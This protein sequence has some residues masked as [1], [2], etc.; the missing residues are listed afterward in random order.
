M[1][2]MLVIGYG[3]ELRSDDGVGPKVA[4]A[5]AAM[6]WPGVDAI[7]CQQLTPELAELIAS[8]RAVIFVDAARDSGSEVQTQ[9]IEPSPTA[10]VMAHAGG[11]ESLLA[12][13]REWFGKCPPAWL[14]RVPA[15]TFDFGE[16]L[17]ALAEKGLAEAIEEIKGLCARHDSGGTIVTAIVNR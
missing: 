16:Q 3:N 14:I 15:A 11:P 6:Q 2:A 10:Q 12:L 17:S 5:I 13:A 4:A 1:S 8:A 7:A 9:M